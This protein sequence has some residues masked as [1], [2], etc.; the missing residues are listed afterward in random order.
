MGTSGEEEARVEPIVER[1]EEVEQRRRLR[2][3][4]E[5]EVAASLEDA[6]GQ[7]AELVLEALRL[8]RA[9]EAE[10]HR[11]RGRAAQGLVDEEA[12][13]LDRLDLQR[14]HDRA[15]ERRVVAEERTAPHRLVEPG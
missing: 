12:L 14:A 10:A 5:G 6:R 1:A 11:R 4:I 2:D 13:R 3:R 9:G 8:V 15:E 7:R